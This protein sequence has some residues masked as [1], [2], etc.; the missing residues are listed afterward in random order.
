MDLRFEG[1]LLQSDFSSRGCVGF[2]ASGQK[3][4][5]AGGRIGHTRRAFISP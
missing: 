4:V 5:E 2:G 1:V 3:L